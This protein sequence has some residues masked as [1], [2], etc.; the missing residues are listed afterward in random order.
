MGAKLVPKLLLFFFICNVCFGVLQQQEKDQVV[1]CK[2]DERKALLDF[3]QG[4]DDPSGFLSSWVGQ[5]CCTWSGVQCGDHDHNQHV[6]RLDLVSRQ[7][8]GKISSSLLA[9]KQLQYLDLSMNNF[10]MSIP[11]FFASFDA[12]QYLNLSNAGFKGPVPH[13]LGN[14]TSLRYLDLSNN[15]NSLY[16]VGSR[17]VSN[18]SSLR[19]LNFKMVDLSKAPNLLKSLN[20]LQS[21][22]EIY[23][24]YCKLHIPL[25]L[26]HVNFTSLHLIDLS[27]NDINSTVPL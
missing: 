6:V 4:V 18:L 15:G 11:S 5:E 19:Y 1:F 20:A 7:L 26:P 24:S 13:Q 25:S 27:G 3:K 21:I 2:E 23:L 16:V 8:G 14:L 9:L 10:Q 12:I 17:W 22:S